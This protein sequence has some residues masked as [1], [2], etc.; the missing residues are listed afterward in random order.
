MPQIDH[1]A[2]D[3]LR[4]LSLAPLLSIVRGNGANNADFD[5]QWTE[6]DVHSDD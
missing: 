2:N 5:I 6:R 4:F 3:T 1:A